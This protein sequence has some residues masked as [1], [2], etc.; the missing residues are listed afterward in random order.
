M[1]AMRTDVEPRVRLSA[2]R[3][4]RQVGGPLLHTALEDPGLEQ[5]L[6]EI[7]EAR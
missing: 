4:L 7:L 6:R 1:V 3:S 5:G 2:A